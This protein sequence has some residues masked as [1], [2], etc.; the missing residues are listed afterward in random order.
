MRMATAQPEDSGEC[1]AHY[2]HRRD[3]LDLALHYGHSDPST[4]F[5]H[6][7]PM[8]I[9]V[10]GVGLIQVERQGQGRP[11]HPLDPPRVERMGGAACGSATSA[12]TGGIPSG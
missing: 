11:A 12:A 7:A 6:C 9:S 2:G 5:A 1:F 10:E 3:R 8:Q 4:P